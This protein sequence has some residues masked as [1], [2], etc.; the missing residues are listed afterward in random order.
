MLFHLLLIS[1]VV[2]FELRHSQ[3]IELPSCFAGRNGFL[4]SGIGLRVAHYEQGRSCDAKEN[5]HSYV[6]LR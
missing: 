3:K 5:P 6:L 4:G 2:I 1:I